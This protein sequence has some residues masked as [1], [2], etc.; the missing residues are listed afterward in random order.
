MDLIDTLSKE[1]KNLLEEKPINRGVVSHKTKELEE[2][3]LNTPWY[4]RMCDEIDDPI[5]ELISHECYE[6]ALLIF[7]AIKEKEFCSLDMGYYDSKAGICYFKL[8]D[9]QNAELYFYKAVSDDEDYIDD[10]RE[11]VEALRNNPHITLTYF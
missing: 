3:I 7:F 4:S 5:E 1:I 11:Y 9:Y 8:Q 2:A 6:E 10:I